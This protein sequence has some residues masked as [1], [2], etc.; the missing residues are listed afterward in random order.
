MASKKILIIFPYGHLAYSPTILNLCKLLR[1]RGHEI[2]VIYGFEE[3]WGE[4]MPHLE[5]I[6]L[7]N[8]F[9]TKAT[10]R[11]SRYINKLVWKPLILL[12]KKIKRLPAYHP[13]SFKEALYSRLIKM[14]LKKNRF[15]ECIAVDILP[16][17]WTQ[18]LQFDSHFVSL[19]I[20]EGIRL[21]KSL[22]II[23][24]KSV[25][26]Q[27]QERFERLFGNAT[28]KRFF[29][30][31]APNF[32]EPE[33]RTKASPNLIYNG[34][35]WA[36]FGAYDIIKFVEKYPAYRVHFKGSMTADFR[37]IV[38]SKY[39]SLLDSAV[40]S[41]SESYLDDKELRNYLAEYSIGFC[42]YD[43]KHPL[44]SQRRFNYE[45]APSGKVFMYLSVGMPVIAT[46]IRGFKFLEERQAGILLDDHQPETIKK[47]VDTILED[48]EN[49]SNN[50]LST[51]QMFSFNE[52]AMPFIDFVSQ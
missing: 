39:R 45:T 52:A 35:A 17:Y 8:V 32:I 41:F 31:N 25:V 16:L 19:E 49:F 46:R 3:Y 48:Y 6:Q 38:E 14:A 44:I 26:I 40:L 34:S 15:D 4:Q 7:E 42:L 23:R 20:D 12:F 30:Q 2:K 50:A 33:R 22:E 11:L 36:P 37:V 24:I 29:I 47:A 51:G 9:Y 1:T 18:Q 13:L 10:I 27:S 43:F 28:I 21:L 5:G